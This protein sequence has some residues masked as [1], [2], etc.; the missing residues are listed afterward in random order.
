MRYQEIQPVRS[1]APFIECFWTLEGEPDPA[2]SCPE[3]ILPDGCVEVILS[4]AAQFTEI[5]ELAE[6]RLQPS[7]FLVGQMTRPVIIK[8]TGAVSLIGIRFHPGGTFPFV[9]VPMHETTD[10]IIELGAIAVDLQR[11]LVAVSEAEKSLRLKV[12]AIE[13]WLAKHLRDCRYDSRLVELTAK[14]VRAAGKVSVDALAREAGIS[15][16][17]LRRRFLMEVGL[18]PK[19]LCRVLRFQQVFKAV[20]QSNAEWA[21]VAFECGYYDQAHLIGDFRRFAHQTPSVLLANS[22][23]LTEAFSRKHRASD[24][25]NTPTTAAF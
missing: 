4:F 2:E 19:L 1:L 7:Y 15:A 14:M 24:F 10:Q 6:E 25:S 11:E 8:P 12:V 23:W 22:G 21:G 3:R 20:D 5:G 9:R 18:G 16:R 17:Q 13:R